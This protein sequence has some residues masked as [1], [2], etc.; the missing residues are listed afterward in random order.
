MIFD[1]T[2]Y[3]DDNRDIYIEL[4][5]PLTKKHKLDIHTNYLKLGETAKLKIDGNSFAVEV[6]IKAIYA[7]NYDSE[8]DKYYYN[9]DCYDYDYV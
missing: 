3:A 6:E 7:C 4:R 8:K 9:E 5:S 2:A 1:L